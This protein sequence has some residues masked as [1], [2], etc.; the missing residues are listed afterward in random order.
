MRTLTLALLG[1][2]I[3]HPV[4]ADACARNGVL[5]RDGSC[6]RELGDL[7][8]GRV[9]WGIWAGVDAMSWNFDKPLACMGARDWL[10]SP[11]RST[12]GDVVRYFNELYESPANREIRW[13]WAY[14]LAASR[15]RDDT[16]QERLALADGLVGCGFMKP[17]DRLIVLLRRAGAPNSSDK[18]LTDEEF[19][20]T[21][22]KE[23]R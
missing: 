6:W 18:L 19:F 20:G 7:D 17:D 12:A 3:A 23:D 9:V 15:A 2:L 16:P 4:A 11:G 8:K 5:N 21:K 13:H 14:F 10:A 1:F 22:S